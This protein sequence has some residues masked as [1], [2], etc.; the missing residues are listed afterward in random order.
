MA[1]AG[2][3]VAQFK[4]GSRDLVADRQRLMKLS[5]RIPGNGEA[6]ARDVRT[7]SPLRRLF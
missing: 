2:L 4:I 7:P 6:P 3:A 5:H 1:I